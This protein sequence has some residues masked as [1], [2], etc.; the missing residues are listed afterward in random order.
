MGPGRFGR[1]CGPLELRSIHPPLRGSIA[2]RAMAGFARCLPSAKRAFGPAGGAAPLS[3]SAIH[4]LFAFGKVGPAALP[5]SFRRKE[6]KVLAFGQ[7]FFFLTA[8]L[9]RQT[10]AYSARVWP[11]LRPGPMGTLGIVGDTVTIGLRPM[12]SLRLILSLLPE[13]QP[14]R[15]PALAE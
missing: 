7:R 9:A 10:L 11:G 12:I 15:A 4:P 3:P 8:P 5:T 6:A 13:G 1:A 2:L 14:S